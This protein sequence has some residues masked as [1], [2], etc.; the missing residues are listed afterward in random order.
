LDATNAT[1]ALLVDLTTNLAK[2]VNAFE[3]V[4]QDIDNIKKEQEKLQSIRESFEQSKAKRAE[5]M[6][7]QQQAS[8]ERIRK[9]LVGIG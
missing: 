1:I 3:S 8:E 7:K 4:K 5:E 6:N 2:R 9:G